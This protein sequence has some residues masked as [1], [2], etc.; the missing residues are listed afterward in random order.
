MRNL[1]ALLIAL[2]FCVLA[3]QFAEAALPGSIPALNFSGPIKIPGTSIVIGR[4][5]VSVTKSGYFT[6]QTTVMG[7]TV[8]GIGQIAPDGSFTATLTATGRVNL[9]VPITGQLSRDAQ[10]WVI[11]VNATYEGKSYS[12]T[13][14]PPAGVVTSVRRRL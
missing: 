1:P 10:G 12:Y 2:L 9:T 5:T 13:V 4:A 6:S 3:P 14:R 11:A 7:V 8:R